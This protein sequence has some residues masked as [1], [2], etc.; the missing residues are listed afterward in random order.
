M[1][2]ALVAHDGNAMREILQ[3]HLRN[4]RD[5]VLEQLRETAKNQRGAA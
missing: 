1:I 2:E 3:Q 5:V 4:K